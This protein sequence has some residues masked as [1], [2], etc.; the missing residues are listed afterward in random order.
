ML[1]SVYVGAVESCGLVPSCSC[2]IKGEMAARYT[3]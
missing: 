2:A 1:T 3:L